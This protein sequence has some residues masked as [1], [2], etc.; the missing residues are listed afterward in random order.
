MAAKELLQAR[1]TSAKESAMSKAGKSRRPP[2]SRTEPTAADSEIKDSKEDFDALTATMDLKKD[3]KE[4]F[5]PRS[6]G[7]FNSNDG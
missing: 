4:N 5:G 6:S 3:S 1:L 7:Y 2:K